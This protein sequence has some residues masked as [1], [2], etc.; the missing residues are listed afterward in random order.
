MRWE[1]ATEQEG[2]DFARRAIRAGI[3][4]LFLTK[5]NR[6]YIKKQAAIHGIDVPQLLYLWNRWDIDEMRKQ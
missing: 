2:D 5:H 3:T 1:P 4:P 6:P